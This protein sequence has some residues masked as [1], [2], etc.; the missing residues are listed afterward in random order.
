MVTSL[1]IIFAARTGQSVLVGSERARHRERV[2]AD[3][4]GVRS[5]DPAYLR[6]HNVRWRKLLNAELL[7]T[8]ATLRAEHPEWTEEKLDW[9]SSPYSPE[10]LVSVGKDKD[11]N[12]FLESESQAMSRWSPYP[13]M[14]RDQ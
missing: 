11:G 8:R 6:T 13:G 10:K 9:E 1:Q 12:D 4:D 7:T 2:L 5:A 14:T 3:M